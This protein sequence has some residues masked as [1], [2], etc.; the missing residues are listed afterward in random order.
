MTQTPPLSAAMGVW[1]TVGLSGTARAGGSSARVGRPVTATPVPPD[2]TS[3]GAAPLTTDPFGPAIRW[4][5]LLAGETPAGK[6]PVA[7]PG[8]TAG[9]AAQAG[10]AQAGAAEAGAGAT[11][12]GVGTAEAGATQGGAGTAQG[13]A[14]G[15]LARLTKQ[16]DDTTA[17]T[18]P[19]ES[20]RQALRTQAAQQGEDTLR[21]IDDSLSTLIETL[22]LAVVSGRAAAGLA[23]TAAGLVKEARAALADAAAPL[24]DRP[25]TSGDPAQASADAAQREARRAALRAMADRILAKARMVEA[26]ARQAARTRADD[27][28]TGTARAQSAL[29]RLRDITKAFCA[30]R[31]DHL[32]HR[33][34]RF[35]SPPIHTD[36]AP[37]SCLI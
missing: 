30:D 11:Q 28:P 19:A 4:G 13:G 29:G 36:D 3:L 35:A 16:R 14:A 5:G 37:L 17:G 22:H 25:P 32:G 7:G 20:L 23:D 26:A 9:S 2:Q 10:A 31:T 1:Q 24:D 6:H 27:D 34:P 15:A 18:T 21:R 8:S 12:A 33:L